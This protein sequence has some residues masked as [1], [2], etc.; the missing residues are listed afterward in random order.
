MYAL[1]WFRAN[2]RQ[3]A[4]VR[5]E[6]RAREVTERWLFLVHVDWRWIKQRPHWLAEEA[7][8]EYETLVAYRLHPGRRRLPSN[9][10]S[11][12]RFAMLPLPLGRSLARPNS[13]RLFFFLQRAWL[14][15]RTFRFRPTHIYVGHP[16]LYP[17]IP[18]TQLRTAVLVYDCMDDAV[19]MAPA[20][21]RAAVHQRERELVS[22]SA[23]VVASS[24][25]LASR[26]AERYG[27]AAEAKTILVQN[28]LNIEV[29]TPVLR[30]GV[31]A[32]ALGATIGYAGTVARWFDFDSVLFALNECPEVRIRVIGPR[33]GD[34]P[35]HDRIEYVPP[36]DHAKLPELLGD[37]NALIMPFKPGPIVA[38][39]NPV[40]LYEYLT[41]RVPILVSRYEEIEQDFGHLVEMYETDDELAHLFSRLIRGEL[42]PRGDW[43]AVS[44]FLKSSTWTARWNQ[45]Q[46]AKRG[47]AG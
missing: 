2:A 19:A 38:A 40:K 16:K 42:R 3:S 21:Q 32:P 45:I 34:E 27:W 18:R 25:A 13:G 31:A 7:N 30:T 43:P 46:Q 6:D 17:L 26:L 33:I 28:G 24:R 22:A 23:V 37:C 8:K 9:R 20:N 11:V 44:E 29:E 5:N 10:S 12:G 35:R 47:F 1:V 14:G 39:V 36:V 4:G 41:Y 15:L